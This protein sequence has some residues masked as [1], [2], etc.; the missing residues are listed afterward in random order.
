MI[1][2]KLSRKWNNETRTQSKKNKK[3]KRK[4]NKIRMKLKKNVK[5]T[6]IMSSRGK[7]KM[8]KLPFLTPTSWLYTIK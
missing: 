4:I 6:Y 1:R 7:S 3:K 8:V 5:M 2:L